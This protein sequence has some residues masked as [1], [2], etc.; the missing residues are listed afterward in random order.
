MTLEELKV[1]AYDKLVEI[2]VAQG[3][4]QKINEQMNKLSVNTEEKKK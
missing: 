1:K 3:E 2:Q 4:L